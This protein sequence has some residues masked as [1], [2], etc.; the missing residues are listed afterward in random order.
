MIRQYQRRIED[1]EKQLSDYQE[2]EAQKR[3]VFHLPLGTYARS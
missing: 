1:L 3:K 2:V